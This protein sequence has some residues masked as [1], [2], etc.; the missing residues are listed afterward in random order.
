MNFRPRPELATRAATGI[1]PDGRRAV[2]VRLVIVFAGLFASSAILAQHT[3]A[4]SANAQ[5][6][7][8][9][10]ILRPITVTAVSEL[11]FGRLQYSGNGLDGYVI[12][13]A[14]P[15]PTR[16]AIRVI[17]LP[18]GGERAFV[19]T[20]HG[21]PGRLYRVSLP[22][23]VLTTSGRLLVNEFTLWTQNQ[24]SITATR[25]GTFGV[26]GSDTLRVGGKLTI[27]K[28]TR[29]GIYEVKVPVTISYE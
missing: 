28:G 24:Q 23:S 21:E 15:P 17:L 10:T 8:S 3:G 7:T 16:S 6:S 26:N 25:L 14:I 1:R 19:R 20:L 29:Q 22:E 4:Q 13:P 27:P 12:L 11:S 5:A 9:V 2:L 18:N